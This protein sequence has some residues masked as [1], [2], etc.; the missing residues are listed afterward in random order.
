MDT[1][2]SIYMVYQW[3]HENIL[4]NS[5]WP[6]VKIEVKGG[7]LV[8]KWE[9]SETKK[10]MYL[11]LQRKLF[12][13]M[14][15]GWFPPKNSS[16]LRFVVRDSRVWGF[17]GCAVEA[18]EPLNIGRQI[19]ILSYFKQKLTIGHKGKQFSF[20]KL[21]Y[22]FFRLTEFSFFD[23]AVSFAINFLM[24]PNRFF[25]NIF[26]GSLVHHVAAKKCNHQIWEFFLSYS[27]FAG[28]SVESRFLIQQILHHGSNQ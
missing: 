7:H 24:R 25:Q 4:E 8:K 6:P 9:F 14:N 16:K 28:D 18:L 3:P 23:Q 20:K 15:Y 2:L 11:V 27:A 12:A 17:R 13:F 26:M 1:F 22:N 21:I 5:I 10:I 19:S